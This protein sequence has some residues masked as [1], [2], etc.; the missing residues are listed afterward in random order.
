MSLNINRCLSNKYKEFMQDNKLEICTSSKDDR[1]VKNKPYLIQIAQFIYF[2]YFFLFKMSSQV[3]T[4]K[5]FKY[6]IYI[7]R[8]WKTVKATNDALIIIKHSVYLL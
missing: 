1:N 5:I 8:F 7:K 2:I 3:S 4:V 6:F